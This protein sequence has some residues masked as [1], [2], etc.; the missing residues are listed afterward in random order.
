MFKK[1]CFLFLLSFCFFGNFSLAQ[2]HLLVVHPDQKQL[3]FSF[4]KVEGKL[5]KYKNQGPYH[6]SEI[7]L[8]TNGSFVYYFLSQTRFDLTIGN[9][10]K[11]DGLVTLNWDSLKTMAAVNDTSVY[12]KYFKFKPPTP[13]KIKDKIYQIELNSLEQG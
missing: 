3:P 10:T 1:I 8:S 6:I 9:Y 13:F 2:N 11:T 12:K 5:V 4:T 7:E